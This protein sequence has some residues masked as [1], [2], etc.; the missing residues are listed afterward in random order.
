MEFNVFQMMNQTHEHE[1]HL[2]TK[3]LNSKNTRTTREQWKLVRKRKEGKN[4]TLN[5][6]ETQHKAIEPI[7]LNKNTN[8]RIEE[9]KNKHN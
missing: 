3:Q 5:R 6:L 4:K 9:I 8:Y 7:E 2:L 1:S